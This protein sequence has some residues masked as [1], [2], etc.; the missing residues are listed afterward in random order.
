MKKPVYKFCKVCGGQMYIEDEEYNC[1]R[2][3]Y[4]EPVIYFCT[5]CKNKLEKKG[6]IYICINCK[7]EFKSP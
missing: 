1:S 2:C 7:Y 4:Q 6:K 5:F 3:L